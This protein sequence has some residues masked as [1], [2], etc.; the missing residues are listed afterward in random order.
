MAS[1]SSNGQRRS[2]ARERGRGS[3]KRPVQSGHEARGAGV[4]LTTYQVGAL[5]IINDFLRRMK[6]EELLQQHLPADDPRVELPTTRALLVLVRNILVSREPIYGVGDWSAHFAPDLLDLYHNELS[7][8]HDDR[9]GRCLDRMF[10]GAGRDFILALVRHV[11][12]EFQVSLDE[13]HNDSTTVSFH[14]S[15][16]EAKEEGSQ[17]GRATHAITWGH[18]K[19][20]RPDLKQL[21]YTLTVTEDG[22]VPVYFSSAS[23]NVVDDTTHRDTWDL[24]RE[25]IGR[26]DFLYVADCKLASRENLGH[27]AQRGGRFVTVLPATHKEDQEFRQQLREH[28][29]AICWIDLYEVKDDKEVVRDTLAVCQEEMLSKEGYRLFWYRSTRK[30][31]LDRIARLRRIERAVNE[32]RQLNLRLIGP[33]TRFRER[34]KVEAAVQKILDE[35]QVQ[36]FLAIEITEQTQAT[37]KQ[38]TPGRPSSQTKYVRRAR[39]GY[40]V[41]GQANA[42]AVVKAEEEDGVF[43][44]LTN[45]LH[46][47]AEEVLRAY[48]RQPL[49]EKRFSQF[50]ND[51]TVAPVYLKNVARVQGLLAVYFLVLLIQTL[52]ER[53]LRRALQRADEEFLPLYP[54]SRPCRR[55]TTRR[56]LDAFESVQRH[57]L[58]LSDGM[59]QTMVTQLTPLQHQVLSLLKLTPGDYGA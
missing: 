17:R 7:M 47:T 38:A 45:D 43:P 28:P 12:A 14:G 24:L 16:E 6:L 27:I 9:L 34:S 49:I 59:E 32:L 10:D 41:T 30:K 4:Q 37:Y 3:E 51:F 53:E 31:E 15:Y 22:G 5:P 18:S 42:D 44:L 19:D 26:P 35:H 57:V 36:P 23:G 21:L 33:R 58:K 2:A 48:K 11:I 50:K 46:F 39:P 54:E 40:F 8:L 20:H 56:V 25:L 1:R 13:L 55:P 52:L 29:A